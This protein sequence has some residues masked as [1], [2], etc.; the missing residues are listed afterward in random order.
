M[1]RGGSGAPARPKRKKKVRRKRTSTTGYVAGS[2][3]GGKK[4][5]VRPAGTPPPATD[6][7]PK[8]KITA[9]TRRRRA[10]RAAALAPPSLDAQL[11]RGARRRGRRR[12]REAK[13]T[14]RALETLREVPSTGPAAVSRA[15]SGERPSPELKKL[16]PE[17]YEKADRAFHQ[18]VR[19]NEDLG[20][21]EDLTTL[22]TAGIPGG[23]A[24]G[25][26]A[27]GLLKLGAK[28]VAERAAT[29]AAGQTEKVIARGVRTAKAPKSATRVARNAG[30]RVRR[31]APIKAPERAAPQF[32]GA[33]VPGTKAAKIA[34]GQSLPV[35]RGHE[36][37]VVES[38]ITTIKTTAKAVPGLV[39]APVG[40]LYKAGQSG[41][42]SISEVLNEVGVPGFRGYTDEEIISPVKGEVDAQMEFARQVARTVTADDP[43]Y[44]Q[45]EVESSLGLLLPVMAGLAVLPVGKRA[46]QGRVREKVRELADAVRRNP[47]G[48]HRGEAPRV[49]EQPGQRKDATLTVANARGRI[50]REAQQRTQ[51]TRRAGAKAGGSEVLRRG[52]GAKGRD[53]EI[54]TGDLTNFAVR[55]SLPLDD[56]ERALAKV[57]QVKAS[58]QELPPEL[59][60]LALPGERVSTR[61]A[62][63][64]VE[65]NPQVLGDPK[66][67][68]AVESYRSD[69]KWARE[70][71]GIVPEASES[72]R[73]TP[74]AVVRDIPLRQERVPSELRREGAVTWPQQRAELER[75][76]G[77]A[78][79]NVEAAR[80]QERI[81]VSGRSQAQRAYGRTKGRRERRERDTGAGIAP[82][83]AEMRERGTYEQA[84]RRAK[85]A[86]ADRLAA[87]RELAALKGEVATARRGEEGGRV[88]VPL[89]AAERAAAIEGITDPAAR[90][91]ALSEA[92]LDKAR[93]T[94]EAIEDEFVGE[95][96]AR[97]AEEGLPEPEYTYTGRAREEPLAGATGAQ[98]SRVPGKSK[99][100]GGDAERYGI[101]DEGLE[102]LLQRSIAE[103]ISR[104]ESYRAMRE[105]LDR[106]EFRQGRK[107]EFTSAE[108]RELFDSGAISRERYVLVPRQLYKRTA[109]E[110]WVP[111]QWALELKAALDEGADGALKAG[112][113]FKLVRRAAAEEFFDQMAAGGLSKRLTT[114][115]RATSYLILA[116]SPAWATAQ[117]LAEY[118][119]AVAAQPKLLNPAYVRK[120]RDEY[121]QM[122]PE[123]R[124]AFESWVGVTT[125][126]LAKPDDMK[127]TRGTGDA[128]AFANAYSVWERTTA[129]RAIKAIPT[130]IR[131]FDRW[132]GGKIRELVTLA[133]IHGDYK[134]S[135]VPFLRGMRGM[136]DVMKRASRDLEGL[137]LAKQ[138]DYIAE[139]PSLSRAY[140]SYLDDVMGNWSALTKNERI[141]SQLV[142]FYPFIRMS[143]RWAFLTYPRRHPIRLAMLSYL[144]QQNA[145]TLE[146]L[147]GGAPSYFSQWAMI[148]VDIGN[149]ETQLV[150]LSRIAPGSNAVVEAL[151]EGGSAALTAPLR[152]VQPVVGA[153]IAA[154]TGVDR[155]T[156]EQPEVEGGAKSQLLE[157]GALALG[158]LL[159]LSPLTRVPAERVVPEGEK[160]TDAAVPIVGPLFGSTER[161]DSLSKLF[162][163]LRE[164]DTAK[165]TI[166][167]A[168]ISFL[169]K[170]AD[171]ERDIARLG[172]IL[173]TIAENSRGKR[174]E[175]KY[176]V[177]FGQGSTSKTARRIAEMAQLYDEANRELDGLFAKYSVAHKGAE[178]R[179]FERAGEIA[180]VAEAAGEGGL[181]G[182]LGVREAQDGP[183]EQRL[184][185]RRGGRGGEEEGSL[186]ERLE[187][188]RER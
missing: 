157:R 16:D 56:P 150:D 32:S 124:L 152:V 50:R 149:G 63:A 114:L 131:D 146:R 86:R 173:D 147:L 92:K 3:K 29:Q 5:T 144:G 70:T 54:H 161:K 6:T 26:A 30:R 186:V 139:H 17:T 78:K 8:S 59:A 28:E 9:R 69:A 122:A 79:R 64:Y 111:E 49:F 61:D 31:K 167:Q 57:R 168:G 46:S 178:E 106:E 84:K 137:P 2:P 142:I 27:K 83:R 24:A 155:L 45:R 20:E 52:V 25:Q 18:Y 138:L 101:V 15:R 97:L 136:D 123:K 22:I 89:S 112:R 143:L 38:P 104:R 105:L 154:A 51:G 164:V 33:A 34:A 53:V 37:A 109:D 85:Q 48:S 171:Y 166:R 140:Q 135:L 65:R 23:L 100:R 58:L 10:E 36:Q 91:K 72:A 94:S 60:D 134:P 170:K 47:H 14:S 68:E 145:V 73:Y 169:P 165:R 184:K 108:A 183:L 113:H 44:V 151:G 102:P 35:V 176:G 99:F 95:T 117:V 120:L 43:D 141:A 76:L 55:H 41:G 74:A 75:E 98:L 116:T 19:E 39:T 21:P 148:P 77:G 129:G 128:E 42:R 187:R 177:G 158:Q 82:S 67:R 93:R 96:S 182:R 126:E 71:P 7:P 66:L 87:E 179:G 103:P 159:M 188:R 62:I 172:R 40:L 12:R 110:K 90:R 119:Q 185:S 180:D 11:Q 4:G 153:M 13:A 181:R 125:R 107:S 118:A 127:L 88:R 160:P 121:K 156:G 133:K 115:N 130:S 132:K 175:L 80:K 162:A 81:A 163:K 174:D 1:W